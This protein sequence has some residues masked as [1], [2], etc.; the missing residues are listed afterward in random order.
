MIL[1]TPNRSVSLAELG[2]TGV[3]EQAAMV[4]GYD[5][6]RLAVLHTAVRTR[7]PHEAV[8]MGTEGFI[9]LHS[10]WWIPKSFTVDRPGKEPQHYDFPFEANGYNYEAAEVQ[11]CLRTGLTESEIMPL[12]ETLAIMETMDQMRAQWGLRYPME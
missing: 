2:Q 12:D 8:I 5:G 9:R 11:R 10:P 7:S 1:G 4:L 6:G 3:D